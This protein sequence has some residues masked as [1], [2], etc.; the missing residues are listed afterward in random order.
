VF[1]DYFV[2]R[3]PSTA[4]SGMAAPLQPHLHM[5]RFPVVG[6]VED[7]FGPEVAGAP[8]W[9]PSVFHADALEF[10]R[11]LLLAKP[12]DT[13]VQNGTHR[14]QDLNCSVPQMPL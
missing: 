8:F 14:F 13:F 12:G 10:G 4:L 5:R 7:S 1:S 2:R 3:L 6:L 11:V 9:P